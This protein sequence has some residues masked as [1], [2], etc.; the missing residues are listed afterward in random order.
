MRRVLFLVLFSAAAGAMAQQRPPKLE[1]LPEPPP[2]PLIRDGADEPRVR[3]APQ[4]GD[5][6]EEVRDG[7]RVVMMKVTPPNGVPYYLLDTLGNGN[8]T[9]REA[10]DPGVRVPMW[11]IKTFD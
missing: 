9:R 4:E 6:V 1:P 2:P 3:I 10:L 8:W 5:K 11:T 7:G